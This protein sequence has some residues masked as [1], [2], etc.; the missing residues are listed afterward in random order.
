MHRPSSQQT[1][2]NPRS[3]EHRTL[4]QKWK[5]PNG[6]RERFAQAQRRS[7]QSRSQTRDNLNHNNATRA[8][9]TLR[10]GGRLSKSMQQLTISGLALNSEEIRIELPSKKSRADN[11]P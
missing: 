2:S 7:T 4:L 3:P 1:H 9:N 11:A 8:I 5:E 10:R 6:P